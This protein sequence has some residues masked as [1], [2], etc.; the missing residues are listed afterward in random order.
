MSKRKHP[1]SVPLMEEPAVRELLEVMKQHNSPDG[2][3]LA[4]CQQI[5]GAGTTAQFRIGGAVCDAAG[6]GP[7]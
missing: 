3:L 4:M 6:A 2:D 5:A 7:G 1:R